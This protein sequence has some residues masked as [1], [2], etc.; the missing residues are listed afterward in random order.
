MG[1]KVL[2]LLTAVS[3]VGRGLCAGDMDDLGIPGEENSIASDLLFKD[4]N[5]DITQFRRKLAKV[6]EWAPIAKDMEAQ[7]QKMYTNRVKSIVS[8]LNKIHDT[9]K[10]H[11]N[12]ELASLKLD[13][14]AKV[15]YETFK[16]QGFKDKRDDKANGRVASSKVEYISYREKDKSNDN[17]ISENEVKN[18]IKETT[19]QNNEL[20]ICFIINEKLDMLEKLGY[21]KIDDDSIDAAERFCVIYNQFLRRDLHF[22][23]AKQEVSEYLVDYAKNNQRLIDYYADFL[24]KQQKKENLSKTID[25]KK[26]AFDMRAIYSAV[27]RG[28]VTEENHAE[29]KFYFEFLND[30]FLDEKLITEV[31]H[32]NMKPKR[33]GL[34]KQQK[35]YTEKVL[36]EKILEKLSKLKR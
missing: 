20:A 10:N 3:L 9:V 32:I 23:I 35:E 4:E 8:L 27:T 22:L 29:Y 16:A 30:V 14:D 21:P 5:T 34:E 24:R 11:P 26:V 18:F 15:F 33:R 13:A 36:L 2:L 7:L 17:I 28:K 19:K 6:R 12:K 25:F 31:P 1:I